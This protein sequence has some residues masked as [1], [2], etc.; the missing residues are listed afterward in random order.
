MIRVRRIIDV[1]TFA[2]IVGAIVGCGDGRPTRVPVSGQVLIDGKPLT[3]GT[4]QFM[5]VGSRASQGVVDNNGRFT[6]TCFGGEDGAVP[7][8]H[9]VA[10]RAGEPIGPNKIR[11][12]AP[13]KYTDP[14]TSG[15]SEKIQGDAS[16]VV[17]R[18][19]WDGG[20]EFVEITDVEIEG[21]PPSR[22]K[23]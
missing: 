13:K 11:W 19:S 4:I 5:P 1:C 7:G 15:L 12:H 14:N 2:A 23:K 8:Q 17:I 16:N 20:H 21:G 10:I 3:Y 18:L 9:A 22:R 6:L